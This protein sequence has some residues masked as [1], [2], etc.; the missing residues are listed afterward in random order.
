MAQ[1]HKN[2]FFFYRI[3]VVRILQVSA[4]DLLKVDGPK[5]HRNN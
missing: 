2:G 5:S 1:T 4:K 3:I